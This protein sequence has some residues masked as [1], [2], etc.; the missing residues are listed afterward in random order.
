MNKREPSRHIKIVLGERQ[1]Q[2]LDLLA[3]KQ[4]RTM[5]SVLR[6]AIEEYTGVPDT[7]AVGGGYAKQD[8][9]VRA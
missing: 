6:E 7:V 5:S 1:I 9:D 2:A 4:K 8:E 3:K